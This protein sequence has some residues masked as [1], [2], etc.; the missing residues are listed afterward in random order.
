MILRLRIM[1]FYWIIIC[2]WFVFVNLI[3]EGS[4]YCVNIIIEGDN[5]YMVLYNFGVVNIVYYRFIC[6]VSY[7]LYNDILSYIFFIKEKF[8]YWICMF[9]IF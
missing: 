3:E 4:V 7:L 2:K 9:E 6:Y 8:K 5:Y 1:F